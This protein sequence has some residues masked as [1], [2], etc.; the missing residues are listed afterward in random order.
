MITME[1]LVGSRIDYILGCNFYLRPIW[2]WF[3]LICI[4]SKTCVTINYI[5]VYNLL[6]YNFADNVGLI[7]VNAK[8]C[9]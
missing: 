6:K 4:T 8:Y 9:E 5:P 3:D 7:R 2:Y 1:N